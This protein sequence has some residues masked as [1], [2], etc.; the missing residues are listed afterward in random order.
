M[1]QL[2]NESQGKH[3]VLSNRSGRWDKEKIMQYIKGLVF[4]KVKENGKWVRRK[5]RLTRNTKETSVNNMEVVTFVQ[6]V[7]ARHL[8]LNNGTV[9]PKG[10]LG[11]WIAS[12]E[13]L[14]HDGTCWLDE[15][16]MADYESSITEDAYVS[17]KSIITRGVH[18][19]GQANLVHS[20]VW[21]ETRISGRSLLKDGRIKDCVID[22]EVAI[23]DSDIEKST[24][25]GKVIVK[26]SKMKHITIENPYSN[27]YEIR[28]TRLLLAEDG[29][30]EVNAPIHL[31]NCDLTLQEFVVNNSLSMEH[32][33]GETRRICV[34]VPTDLKN[35]Q[36]L[37]FSQLFFKYEKD[38]DESSVKHSIIGLGENGNGI[39]LSGAIILSGT[40]GSLI[41]GKVAL[42]GDIHLVD[43]ELHDNFSI[44][45]R[46]F[47]R[48]DT[49]LSLYR[50]KC[51]DFSSMMLDESMVSKKIQVENL[52]LESDECLLL[53]NSLFSY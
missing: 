1:G 37:R 18:V 40:K 5:Y 12:E 41:D 34:L 45:M 20:S 51:K 7:A 35:I 30:S 46:Q 11:G 47:K 23:T 3:N 10:T 6:I 14:S 31:R 26:K 13:C 36:L 32:V 39:L 28:Y 48:K 21:G 33:K 50:S 43:S 53:D 15:K 22:G 19:S 4:K 27:A 25:T 42:Q 2:G 49:Y 16:S 52:L 24:L 44:N 17:K 8:R 38:A 9:I 29:K